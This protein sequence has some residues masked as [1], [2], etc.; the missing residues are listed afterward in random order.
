[1]SEIKSNQ[2]IKFA[3]DIAEERIVIDG[4]KENTQ[5]VTQKDE[6]MKNI[7]ESM[8]DGVRRSRRV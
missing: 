3:V 1:M 4:V 2:W 7:K 8:E 5:K 6:K